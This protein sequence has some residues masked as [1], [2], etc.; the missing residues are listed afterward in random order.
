MNRIAFGLGKT[1]SLGK[2]SPKNWA[3]QPD[4]LGVEFWKTQKIQNVS[5]FDRLGTRIAGQD[6]PL[7]EPTRDVA[8]GAPME[9]WLSASQSNPMN[10]W[11]PW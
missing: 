4:A 6:A 8:S 7:N 5:R 1:A 11:S 2:V 3:D 10:A 9:G